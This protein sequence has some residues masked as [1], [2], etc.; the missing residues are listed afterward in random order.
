M[1]AFSDVPPL[2]PTMTTN[3]QAEKPQSMSIDEF[4]ANTDEVLAQIAESR[5]PMVLTQNGEAV[6]V[7]RDIAAY[8]Q[9]Q[10]AVALLA[11]LAMGQRQIAEGKVRAAEEVFAQLDAEDES[12]DKGEAL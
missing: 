4:Q 12:G 3:E 9:D 7:V 2:E 6:A 8:E 10:E 1:A 5:K 11:A